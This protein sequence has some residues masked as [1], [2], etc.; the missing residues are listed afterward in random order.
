MSSHQSNIIDSSEGEGQVCLP[1]SCKFCNIDFSAS[2]VRNNVTMTNALSN[3]SL[4]QLRRAVGLR[5]QIDALTS[6]LNAIEG[7]PAGAGDVVAPRL[8]RPP[9]K[10]RRK[11]R[12]MT[13]AALNALAQARAKRWANVN[14]HAGSDN[15]PVKRKKRFSA[16]ARAALS[17]AAKARWRK[18]KAAGK[19]AL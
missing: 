15:P 5:E 19:S 16:A 17:A 11:R 1:S 3:L 13:P 18:A 6:E 4:A 10:G 2:F 8:G 14:G 9:G 7:G 12:T